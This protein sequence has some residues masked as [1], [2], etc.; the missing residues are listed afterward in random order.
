M[1]W[2][3][4]LLIVGLIAMVI[5]L[6]CAFGGS[7]FSSASPIEEALMWL[8]PIGAIATLAAAIWLVILLLVEWLA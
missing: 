6:M 3:V 2:P 5:G 4:L 1:F 7:L 8:F